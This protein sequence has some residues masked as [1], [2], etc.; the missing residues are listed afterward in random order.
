MVGRLD[1]WLLLA[2]IDR[3]RQQSIFLAYSTCKESSLVSFVGVRLFCGLSKE[4]QQRRPDWQGLRVSEAGLLAWSFVVFESFGLRA[5]FSF[6]LFGPF[7]VR[8]F[9]V[10]SFARSFLP[11]FLRLLRW[12]VGWLGS[13]ELWRW[14]SLFVV[15]SLPRWLF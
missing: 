7:G 4:Q 13:C 1:S 14:R 5:A 6:G 12:S 8:S 11:S 9:G 15:K 2:V 10:R 3:L